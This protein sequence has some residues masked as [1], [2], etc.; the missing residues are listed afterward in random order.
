MPGE[1]ADDV[2]RLPCLLVFTFD[3]SRVSVRTRAVKSLLQSIGMWSRG[4]AESSE[5]Y[6]VKNHSPPVLKSVKIFK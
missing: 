5:D 1:P 6:N 3:K 4:L 2:D